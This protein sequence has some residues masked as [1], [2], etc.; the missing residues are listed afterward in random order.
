MSTLF[1]VQSNSWIDTDGQYRCPI[2]QWVTVFVNW[3]RW[4]LSMSE[5]SMI[6]G[7]D[8]WIDWQLRLVLIVSMGSIDVRF[9]HELS[10]DIEK[11]WIWRHKY[12]IRFEKSSEGC[13]SA[14][15][16]LSWWCWWRRWWKQREKPVSLWLLQEKHPA[17]RLQAFVSASLFKSCSD[18]FSPTQI[19]TD[20]RKC[21]D[22]SFLFS[23]VSFI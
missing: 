20:Y 5:F 6:Q 8:S 23:S 14:G 12:L 2:F 21:D 4:K 17:N 22:R 10:S 11:I 1:I 3:Y 15:R 9:S 18:C 19:Q 7:D 16:W 13:L